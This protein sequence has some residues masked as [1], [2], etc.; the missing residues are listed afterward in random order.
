[1]TEDFG[2]RT[3]KRKPVDD[4]EGG[5]PSAIKK[6]KFSNLDMDLIMD[7][8]ADAV[9]PQ[10]EGY[11]Q[12][13]DFGLGF[14]QQPQNVIEFLLQSEGFDQ[15]V[16]SQLDEYFITGSPEGETG[17]FEFSPP[18]HYVVSGTP[19]QDFVFGTPEQDVEMIVS[20]RE[21][22][23]VPETLPV[24]QEYEEHGELGEQEEYVGDEAAVASEEILEELLN[25]WI[26]DAVQ[27]I[28][29]GV[30]DIDDMLDDVVADAEKD[31]AEAR[32][33]ITQVLQG[34]IRKILVSGTEGLVVDED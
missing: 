3:A 19:E 16:D 10:F 17:Y 14:D 9:V 8:V 30:P 29:E 13:F 1:M 24:T 20:Q 32:L 12:G 5:E 27:D 11:S 6:L 26:N 4:A 31:I 22:S 28:P 25:G 21:G 33:A 2:F 18:E 15:N 34:E 7:A 23:D